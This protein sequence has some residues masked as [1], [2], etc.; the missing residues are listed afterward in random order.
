M[1]KKKTEKKANPRKVGR[2]SVL[3]NKERHYFEVHTD[4]DK[5]KCTI[6]QDQKVIEKVESEQMQLVKRPVQKYR[7]V[8]E[9]DEKKEDYDRRNTALQVQVKKTKTWDKYFM[10]HKDEIEVYLEN[11]TNPEKVMVTSEKEVIERKQVKS[12]TMYAKLP[13]ALLKKWVLNYLKH[14]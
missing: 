14:S 2:G 1:A 11:E 13:N 5:F 3:F 8:A 7:P 10:D 9:K 4:G 6:Y 12:T